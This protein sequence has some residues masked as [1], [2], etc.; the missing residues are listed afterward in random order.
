MADWDYA[1][2][3]GATALLDYATDIRIPNEKRARRRGRNREIVWKQGERST[4]PK[5]YRALDFELQMLL[6]YTDSAGAITH[7]DGAPGHVYEN[8]LELKRLLSGDQ[9]NGSLI[10]LRRTMPHAGIVD[11]DFEV[12]DEIRPGDTRFRMVAFCRAPF[13]YWQ[14]GTQTVETEVGKT[15][16]TETIEV[17]VGGNEGIPNAVIIFAPDT[18]D[19]SNLRITHTPSGRFLQYSGIITAGDTVTF[20][21]GERTVVHSV[22]GAV[23]AAL[24]KSH[25]DWLVLPV[26]TYNLDL[27]CDAGTLDYDVTVSYY[28]LWS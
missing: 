8:Y 9:I 5:L 23:D 17:V 3:I 6:A 11:I 16:T 7:T 13:P 14:A 24:L 1:Y 20:D 22:D 26:G 4:Q 12:L 28:D 2:K 10:T 25:A 19:V 27:T 15:T 18:Q 21:V